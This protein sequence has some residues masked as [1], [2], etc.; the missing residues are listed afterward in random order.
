MTGRPLLGRSQSAVLK[1]LF[2][3]G[4]ALRP[5]SLERDWQRKFAPSLS[6]RGLI[7][8]WYRQTF[9]DDF[10]LRGPFITLSVAGAALANVLFNRAPRRLSG[11]WINDNGQ[12]S[13]PQPR[14]RLER[15]R[16]RT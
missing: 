14:H 12:P 13:P 2:A 5:V 11:A 10:S 6:R 9:G 7:E 1:S 8:I 4:A 3:R 15:G 16:T